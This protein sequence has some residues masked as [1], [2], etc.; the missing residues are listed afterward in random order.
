MTI[1]TASSNNAQSIRRQPRKPKGSRKMS[2]KKS[3]NGFTLDWGG[4]RKGSGRPKGSGSGPSESARQNR[5]LIMI[6]RWL[7]EQ[8]KNSAERANKPMATFVYS[9]YNKRFKWMARKS[10]D[11]N[12]RQLIQGRR[13]HPMAIRLSNS[14]FQALDELATRMEMPVATVAYETLLARA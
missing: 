1:E 9:R 10:S 5:V 2:A 13:V 14:E 12:R 11:P 7:L 8:L 6:P 4:F 3:K